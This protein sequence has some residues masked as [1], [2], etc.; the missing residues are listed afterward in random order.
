MVPQPG[1]AIWF[2][3]AILNI[4]VTL[5]GVITQCWHFNVRTL[6]A[7]WLRTTGTAMLLMGKGLNY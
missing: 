7:S 5:N 3:A 6:L 2:T 4:Q 1:A